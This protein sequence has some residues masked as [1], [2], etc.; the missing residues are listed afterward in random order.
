M[1]AIKHP[2]RMY[3]IRNL[4]P[5]IS[6]GHFTMKVIHHIVTTR[7]VTNPLREFSADFSADA[8][9]FLAHPSMRLGHFFIS[10]ISLFS[11][12]FVFFGVFSF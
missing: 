8:L 2:I 10:P 11:V 3:R 5:W 12:V 9:Y 7:L 6:A 4:A 1:G